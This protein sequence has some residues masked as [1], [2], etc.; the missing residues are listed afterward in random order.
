[1]LLTLTPVKADTPWRF[2]G[3]VVDGLDRPVPSVSIRVY[4]GHQGMDQFEIDSE[5][6]VTSKVDGSFDGVISGDYSN[7]YRTISKEPYDLVEACGNW[8]TNGMVR[9]L[10]KRTFTTNEV[11]AL[12]SAQGSTLSSNIVFILSYDWNFADALCLFPTGNRLR[13]AVLEALKHPSKQ[14]QDGAKRLL[15]QHIFHP[16]D[17]NYSAGS[18]TKR[19]NERLTSG[20]LDGIVKEA[21]A[22]VIEE[23]QSENP[24]V[25]ERILNQDQNE[26]LAFFHAYA[27]A[28][29]HAASF[30][31]HFTKT[32]EVWVFDYWG[33]SFIE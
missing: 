20:T 5:T 18:G 10:Q 9:L 13:P 11:A 7:T 28:N 22:S 21:V 19:P 29:G 2:E 12:T 33:L 31:L 27:T 4:N 15:R 26:A 32:H 8:G 23:N 16:D 25:P 24:T 30:Y 6:I 17:M 3:T 1:M 14:I